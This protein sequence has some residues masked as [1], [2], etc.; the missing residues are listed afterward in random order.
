MGRLCGHRA[1]Q[2][3]AWNRRSQPDHLRDNKGVWIPFVFHLRSIDVYE[4]EGALYIA[5]ISWDSR[6]VSF[7]IILLRRFSGKLSLLLGPSTRVRDYPVAQTE[8]ERERG[9][10]G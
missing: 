3:L 9:I 7:V 5:A 2:Y 8:R 4:Y 1:H 10:P 6:Q